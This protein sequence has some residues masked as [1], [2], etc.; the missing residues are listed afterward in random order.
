M[1]NYE[2]QARGS[3]ADY[4]AYF[5]GMNASMQQKVALTTAHFPN[6]GTVADMG[7][8]SGAGSFDLAALH[9][10]IQVVGVDINPDAVRIAAQ[11]YQ[12]S[13]LQFRVGDIGARLWPDNSLD[14]VLD[15]SVLHHVTSFN[16][17]SLQ[18]LALAL[19]HQV[20]A[21]K[22]GGT[23]V[24]RDFVVPDNAR[25]IWM[26]LPTTDGLPSGEVAELSSAALFER[27]ASEFRSSQ[28]RRGPVP[29]RRVDGAASGHQRYALNQRAATEFVL[30]KDYRDH[31]DVEKLEEYTYYTQAQFEAAFAERRLRVVASFPIFNPWIVNN[32]F[33]GKFVWRD[34]ATSALLPFPATNYLIVGEKVASGAGV[35]I[36]A[37]S[38]NSEPEPS[39]VKLHAYQH[40]ATGKVFELCE[41]PHPTV[42]VMPYFVRGQRCF[43]LAKQGFPRPLS[44]LF[45]QSGQEFEHNLTAT[46]LAGYVT[47]P[48]SA[49]VKEGNT[50]QAV[51]HVLA[52]RAKTTKDS[53]QA[54]VSAR[55]RYYPSPGGISEC[56]DAVC[57]GVAAQDE[58]VAVDNYTAFV[59]AGT[60]RP[61]E[62]TQLLRAHAIGGMFDARL[63][64]NTFHLLREL[65]MPL[66]PWIGESV[67]LRLQHDA[68]L[69][70]ASPSSLAERSPQSCFDRMLVS[71]QQFLQVFRTRFVERDASNQALA[72]GSFEWVRPRAL[73]CNTLS[74]LPCL[75]TER[76]VMIG[77]QAR[78]LPA[79]EVHGDGARL[80]CVPAVRLPRDKARLSDAQSFAEHRLAEE[81]SLAPRQA[82][83][84]GGRY[85]PS[86]GVT[87]EVVHPY[88]LEVDARSLEGG[89]DALKWF[90][91][92][93]V[94]NARV[95]LR[96]AH[97][98][99]SVLRLAHALSL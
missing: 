25:E 34:P 30:R 9:E 45:S 95:H 17:F 58:E 80:W 23:L 82:W 21:L 1:K 43:V 5:A 41:R 48:L 2:Q 84:L 89:S 54:T 37:V 75:R 78:E 35:K 29:Y 98:L 51:S 90:S 39:F 7:S 8:G 6:R 86:I 46:H 15:S 99:V 61:L 67:E 31:Y 44:R 36:D 88:A 62:A 16:D 53:S 24:V 59:S 72:E 13:N 26:D 92:S 47:E 91:L 97:T 66:G 87:P 3:D 70:L 4:A 50:E 52:E 83:S 42:D 71:P 81:F 57:V 94:V 96:D 11:T 93:D 40:R 56:V 76:G 28:N 63:E 85:F 49:I 14:A 65:R 10:Q 77:L 74:L 68:K 20:Q 19:D 69:D 27:F 12:R 18:A 55:L 33:A 79:P 60:V 22:V 64:I 73:S 38:T 32:R